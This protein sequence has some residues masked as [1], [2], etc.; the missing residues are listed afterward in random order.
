MLT[1]MLE[2]DVLRCV[3]VPLENRR[4]LY[5]TMNFGQ[6]QVLDIYILIDIRNTSTIKLLCLR[7]QAIVEGAMS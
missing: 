2:H 4:A 3:E 7:R 6:A 1:Y 5:T